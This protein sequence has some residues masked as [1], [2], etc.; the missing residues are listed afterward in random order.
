M[1]REG[2]GGVRE[3]P[4]TRVD[5]NAQDHDGHTA[6]HC[7]MFGRLKAQWALPLLLAHGANPWIKD[8]RGK[9]PVYYLGPY[10]SFSIDNL[11]QTAMTN[12][13]PRV[14][15]LCKA[16]AAEE[17]EELEERDGWREGVKGGNIPRAFR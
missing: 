2:G 7:A 16:R 12:P 6:L 13:P 5:V 10:R 9:Y 15:S 14:W 4:Q 17:V 8:N 11:L 3:G 1:E